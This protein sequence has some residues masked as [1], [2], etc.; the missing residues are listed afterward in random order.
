MKR[1]ALIVMMTAPLLGYANSYNCH[2][3]DQGHVGS[4]NISLS[5][6]VADINIVINNQERQFKDCIVSNDDF[7][8]LIDCNNNGV[9][10]LLQINNQVEPAEGGIMSEEHN[11]F[12]DIDC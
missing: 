1:L 12:V 5:N 3:N 9:D 4:V 10:F 7:G 2:Y 8:T 6:I 11:L